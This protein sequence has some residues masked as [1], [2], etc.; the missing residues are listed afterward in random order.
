MDTL[1]IHE[2]FALIVKSNH[3]IKLRLNEPDE[4]LAG[5]NKIEIK[6]N[7]NNQLLF[8]FDFPYR[9][10]IRCE[11]ASCGCRINSFIWIS[12]SHKAIWFENPKAA[13]RSIVEALNIKVPSLED[14]IFE[15][16]LT[17]EENITIKVIFPE[18]STDIN[19]KLIKNA[20]SS[21]KLMHSRNN[22]LSNLFY[23]FLKKKKSGF[24]LFYGSPNEVINKYPT[25]FSF[26]FIRNPYD[27]MISNY[28]MFTQKAYRKQKLD[29]L[30][31]YDTTG[32]SLE[33]FLQKSITLRNHHWEKQINYFPYDANGMIKL[34]FLGRLETIQQDWDFIK[35]K[36]N[37][38]KDLN[39]INNTTKNKNIPVGSDI[40]TFID[41]EYKEDIKLFF[42]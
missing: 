39:I 11:L 27:K 34:S 24:Q 22:P 32:I 10:T 15:K 12:H 28:S 21:Y 7:S 35:K 42:S 18:N 14:L 16:L 6:I 20:I 25:Y 30:F 26:A 29:E 1:N 36:I 8:S 31:K 38:D 13:S 23:S 17:A 33:D 5:Q 40:K 3:K 4:K 19:T 37:I 41:K 2:H 9:R